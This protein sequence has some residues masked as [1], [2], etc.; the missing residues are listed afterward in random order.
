VTIDQ[1]VTRLKIAEAVRSAFGG[2]S[3][4]RDEIVAAADLASR[5]EVADVLRVCPIAA[6]AGS[7]SCGRSWQ[8]FR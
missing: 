8:T 6:T 1:R 3:A 5:S 7:T 4:T 2:G